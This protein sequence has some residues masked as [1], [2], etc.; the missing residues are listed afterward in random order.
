L[1][2]FQVIVARTNDLLKERSA[3]SKVFSDGCGQAAIVVMRSG[4]TASATC[5]ALACEANWPRGIKG[6]FGITRLMPPRSERS[7]LAPLAVTDGEKHAE[8]KRRRDKLIYMKAP[9]GGEAPYLADGWNIAK[10]LKRQLRLSKSKSADRAFQDRVWSLFYR[11]GYADLNKGQDFTILHKVAH[12]S[13]QEKRVDIFAKDAETVVVGECKCS[14]D[15]RSRSLSKDIDDFVCFKKQFADAIRAH[16]GREFKPKILW[17]FF[18]DKVLWS[19]ADRAKAAAENLKIMTER[20]VDY[21][22]QLS[23]HLGRA[24]RYQFLA[25]YLGG[26]R[27]P[28]LKDIKVP[29]IRGKLGGKTFY[30]FVSTPE[31]LLKICFVNHRTLA[32][33]LAL[34]TYQ[35]LVKKGRLKSIGEFI[36]NGGYFPTNI[37]INFDERR[38][39]ERRATDELADVQFG[40]L[41]LPDKYKSAWIVDGQHRLYG[42]SLIDQKF[43]KQNVAVIAFEE[44]KRED[45]AN[46][47][48]TINHEQK[49]VPRT[50]LDELDADLKWGSSVPS[51]R[52]ASISA[53]VVQALTETI[54][55]PLFRRVIAQGMQ[56][57]DTTCLTMPEIKG[58]I[59][60]SHLVGSLAQKRRVLVGGPL[61]AD[62]DERTVRRA[63]KAINLFLGNIKMA[64]P[65]RWESGRP[66]WLCVNIGIRAMLLLLNALIDH[67]TRT[68]A[69]FVPTRATPEQIVEKVTNLSAPLREYLGKVS[70]A[71]FCERFA[72]RYGS[73]GPLDYF[74]ELCQIVW[75]KDRNFLPDGLAQYLESKDDQRIQNAENTIKFIE[76]RVTEIIISYFKRIHGSAYWNYIGTKEMRV[77]AYE[78]Q[79]EEPPEQQLDL[80]VYLDFIDK[81]RIIEKTENWNVFKIYF[82]IPLSGQKGHAKNVK[83]MDRLNEL[84]RVVAH[85]HKRA[86]KADDLEFLEWIKKAFAEKLLAANAG[87][88]SVALVA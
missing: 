55:G 21:F 12:N 27:I 61:W 5:S 87:D 54:E 48:V 3:E 10:K 88:A 23:E 11:M 76:N 85:P 41:H 56:G 29:A 57:D 73:G 70:D 33:P 72:G 26:Q 16:Y 34:P 78:R 36:K 77:K 35:R 31:Q 2:R 59:I 50:L 44:L 40:D 68:S 58:G 79:Q 60:R 38:R 66:G 7:P 15:F 22:S 18:T 45:E 17:F 53:R 25:E 28:E 51:E 67:A 20:E 43:S 81:K 37:L 30:S 13:F 14:E 71:E 9:T 47:F 42:Y 19:K 46:L 8:F 75:D 74:Y 62:E 65:V 84:R 1:Y 83:W 24:T 69:D 64:A 39:F 32:D 86:F 63:T 4:G 49:T 52:L 80:E 6:R 82:D